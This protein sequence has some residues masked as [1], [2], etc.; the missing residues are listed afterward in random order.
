MDAHTEARASPTDDGR[1]GRATVVCTTSPLLLDRA[2]TV[3]LVAGGRVV[4]ERTHDELLEAEPPCA[5]VTR[6]RSRE[7]A[8]GGDHRAGPR[9]GP[10]GGRR[11]R[12]A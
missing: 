9:P 10:G 3:A 5:V 7:R 12:G 1:R 6:R 11:H 2:D 4:A 8:A